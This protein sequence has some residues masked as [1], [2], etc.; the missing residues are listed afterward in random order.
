VKID[1]RK[2]AINDVFTAIRLCRYLRLNEEYGRVDV[3]VDGAGIGVMNR[4]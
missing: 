4:S 2:G 3:L 1:D